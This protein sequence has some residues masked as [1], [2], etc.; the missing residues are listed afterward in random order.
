MRRGR[1]LVHA[2]AWTLATGVAV[3]L[4]WYG[5]RTVLTGTA[6][7]AP[8]ALPVSADAAGSPDER[9]SATHRPRPPSSESPSEPSSTPSPRPSPS[10]PST[11]SAARPKG[12]GGGL[13]SYSVTGGRVALDLGPSSAELVS[14]TPDSGWQMRVWTQSAWIR[15]DF[16]A[17]DATASVFV[18]WNGHPPTVQIVEP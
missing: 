17:G 1:G 15:V 14:A 7:D 8:R 5:V 3:A 11:P 6:Y 16:T 4:S 13:R 9:I 10:A 18:T 12:A 2:I